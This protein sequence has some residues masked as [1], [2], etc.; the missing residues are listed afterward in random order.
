MCY[1]HCRKKVEAKL[2]QKN[3]SEESEEETLYSI[4]MIF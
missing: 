4:S 3:S 1:V 2:Q